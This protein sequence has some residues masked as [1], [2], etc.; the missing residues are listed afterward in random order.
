MDNNQSDWFVLIEHWV[1]GGSH[2]GYTLPFLVGARARKRGTTNVTEQYARALLSEIFNSPIKNHI[3]QI[4]LCPDLGVP[5][6]GLYREEIKGKPFYSA[7]TS[8]QSVFVRHDLLNK[9]GDT[10]QEVFKGILSEAKQPIQE[11]LF[12]RTFNQTWTHFSEM[13]LE[14]IDRLLMDP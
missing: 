4:I 1:A 12:S 11:G 9:W 6:F 7:L 5:V 14:R 8:A 3:I 13:E 10:T 2:N